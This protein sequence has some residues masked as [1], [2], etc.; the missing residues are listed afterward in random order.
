[1]FFYDSYYLIL[2]VPA[3]LLAMWAQMRVKS[4]YNKYSQMRA[5]RGTTA[6]QVAR[7]ILRENG[8][9]DIPVVQVPGDLTDHYDPQAREVRLSSTVYGSS[10]VAAIGVAAHEVGH[11]C[12]H[13]TNYVPLTIRRAIIPITNI[14]STLSVPLLLLG[15]V[16]GNQTLA[17]AGVLLFALVAL[18][19]LI[20][21]PVEF[22]ASHRALYTLNQRDILAGEELAGAKKVLTAAALTYVAALA[23]SL[24]QLLRLMLIV[25]SRRRND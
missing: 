11:A 2:V 25:S 16:L 4:T 13:A 1:M 9:S 17:V 23:V 7:S 18:F 8:L 6:A 10:S 12:Q 15:L 19:Q 20:T 3:L 5:S 14:G 24:A 21:L 22:N